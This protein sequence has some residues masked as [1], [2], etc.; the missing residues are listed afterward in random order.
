MRYNWR[1]I[2]QTIHTSKVMLELSLNACRASLS[3]LYM[4]PWVRRMTKHR[5]GSQT[6]NK[7]GHK[8]YILFWRNLS[9]LTRHLIE[10]LEEAV[11]CLEENYQAGF[12]WS[13]RE[14]VQDLKH[15]RETDDH[16][17]QQQLSVG[18]SYLACSFYHLGESLHEYISSL[19]ADDILRFA[20]DIAFM[21]SNKNCMQQVNSFKQLGTTLSMKGQRP[22]DTSPLQRWQQYWRGWTG[23]DFSASSDWLPIA[24]VTRIWQDRPIPHQKP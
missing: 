10:P 1:T 7:K 24:R 5:N 15:H 19:V 6:L 20:H 13:H 22:K 3:N 17:G 11:L 8:L 4:K 14:A 16:L 21:E 12:D 18:T 2:N 23:S 9:T